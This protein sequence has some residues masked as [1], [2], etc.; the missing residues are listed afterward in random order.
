MKSRT[1]AGKIAVTFLIFT[2]FFTLFRSSMAG[3]FSLFYANNG[4]HDAQIS[5]IKSWQSVGILIGMLPSGFLA[6]R[7]GRLKVLNLSAII[8]SFSFFLLILKP[9]FIIFSLAEFLYGIGLAFNSGTLLAYITDLQELNKI[10]PDSRLM[11]KQTA[12]LNIATLIGGNIG[13]WLFGVK[14]TAPVWFGLLGLALYPLFVIIFIKIMGFHDNRAWI[15][16]NRIN[17]F[18]AMMAI[19]KKKSFWILFLVNIGYDCGTQF[20]MIY[21]SIIYVKQLGFNLSF[22]YTAFMCA[23]IFGA[24]LF[25]QISG[26]NLKGLTIISTLCMMLL[27]CSSSIFSNRYMLLVIFLLIE[28]L[29]GL[30]S[31]QISAFSNWAIYGENNKSLMLSTVSFGVEVVVSLS[32]IVDDKIIAAS[33]NLTIMYWVSAAYFALILLA[34][35]LLNKGKN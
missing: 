24:W 11:G 3:I 30:L 22:V 26:K 6:D 31:G 12:I 23:T 28:L 10:K 18:S 7:I 33:S 17:F 20:L 29:M 8:I 9:C 35:P 5:T 34:V 4:I 16:S 19:I 32:L 1:I 21:W 14:M 27:L 13:T 25:Q 15:F 2:A